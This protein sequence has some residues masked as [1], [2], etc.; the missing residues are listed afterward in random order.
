[1][2]FESNA[3]CDTSCD[4]LALI[5]ALDVHGFQSQLQGAVSAQQQRAQLLGLQQETHVQVA[6]A[7]GVYS[8]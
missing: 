2:I 4:C 7:A 8:V 3:V 6:A 1:M 5:A